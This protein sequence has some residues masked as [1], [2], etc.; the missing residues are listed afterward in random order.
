MKGI[1]LFIG[2]MCSVCT[3]SA[4][5]TLKC[6]YQEKYIKDAN[7][8]DK[9]VYDEHVLVI[10]ENRSAYYSRYARIRNEIKDSLLKQGMSAMEIAAVLQ[11]KPRGR[12]LEIYKHQPTNGDY[13][14]YGKNLKLFRFQEELPKI[15]WQIGNETKT[16]L[17]YSCQ[18]AIGSIYG[19]KWT[20]WFTMDIPVS[21]GPWL[22]CGLPGL[23]LEAV[24]TDNIFHFT[25]IELSNDK[26][27]SVEP[28]DKKYIKCTRE[29][30]MQMRAKFEE[31]PLGM[32]Q[33]S[34]GIRTMKVKDANGKD[35]T[36]KQAKGN[37]KTNYYEK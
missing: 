27:L 3:M 4:Q 30:F 37:R 21:D 29:E 12:E 23:I 22:L 11:E 10:S 1:A 20:V 31:D 9:L 35:I 36:T 14:Y 32:I 24:D 34:M 28:S 16:I 5:T 7:H 25:T 6:V 18:K 15:E 13:L 17:G 33:K 2:L 19:R 8:P 26:S